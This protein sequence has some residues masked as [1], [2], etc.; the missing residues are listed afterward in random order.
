MRVQHHA[1]TLS[2]ISGIRRGLTCGLTA[3]ALAAPVAVVA[4]PVTAV[5]EAPAAPSDQSTTEVTLLIHTPDG[6]VLPIAV[7]STATVEELES[8]I[9]AEAGIPADRQ[10]LV[11]EDG[12]E[13]VNTR[14]VAESELADGAVVMLTMA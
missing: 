8:L 12:S 10:V 2:P 14:T 5:A 3:L 6:E 1:R 11:A 9:A 7:D 4:L 13:L